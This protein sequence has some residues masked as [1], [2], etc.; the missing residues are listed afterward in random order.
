ML[1]DTPAALTATAAAVAMP[2]QQHICSRKPADVVIIALVD[3]QRS[4]HH[5]QCCIYDPGHLATSPCQCFCASHLLSI[6]H[7]L[8]NDAG[9][10][11]CCWLCWQLVLPAAQLPLWVARR[12]SS[13]QW[14]VRAADAAG[15]ACAFAHPRFFCA[16]M[17]S[18]LVTTYAHRTIHQVCC[19]AAV[20]GEGSRRGLR[21]CTAAVQQWMPLSV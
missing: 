5:Q 4:Q 20:D 16:A 14:L 7:L 2:A 12:Q 11:C 13:R 10:R 8:T 6:C 17:D 1:W 9:A 18:M 21:L 15:T 19:N 3:A